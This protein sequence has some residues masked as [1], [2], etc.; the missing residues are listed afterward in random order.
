MRIGVFVGPFLA[1]PRPRRWGL[2]AVYFLSIV[3]MLAAAVIALP[4][5][6]T[7]SSASITGR[8]PHR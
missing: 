7:S 1:P 5:S 6:P 2:S 8:P 3:A 4:A